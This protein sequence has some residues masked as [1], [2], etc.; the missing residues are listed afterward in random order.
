MATTRVGPTKGARILVKLPF[1]EEKTGG[2]KP[3]GTLIRVKSSVAK[4]LK[5]QAVEAPRKEGSFKTASGTAKAERLKSG[6]YKL[7]S[8]KLIFASKKSI[9]GKQYKSVSLP[10]CSGASIADVVKYFQSG[11]GKPIGV[12]GIITP[13]GKTIMWAEVKVTK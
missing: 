8:V 4:L 11:A 13:H 3:A 12:A 10:L 6:A 5:F 2:G 9:D 1:A 7:R